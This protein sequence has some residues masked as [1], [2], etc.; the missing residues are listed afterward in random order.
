MEETI[1]AW[2]QNPIVMGVLG[3]V[4]AIFIGVFSGVVLTLLSLILIAVLHAVTEERSIGVIGLLLLL[5]YYGIGGFYLFRLLAES[6]PILVIALSTALTL[7]VHALR[8]RAL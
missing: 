6:W 8:G 1:Q 2:G 3:V 7:T 5:A 4:S